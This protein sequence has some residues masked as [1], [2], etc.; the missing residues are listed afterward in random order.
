MRDAIWGCILQPQH[1]DR[2]TDELVKVSKEKGSSAKAH[3]YL[4]ILIFN[5]SSE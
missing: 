4:A 5:K 3:Y 1:P 2:A